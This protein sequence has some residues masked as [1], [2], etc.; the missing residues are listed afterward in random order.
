MGVLKVNVDG[1]WTEV[2]VTGAT[3]PKGDKGDTGATGASS[4]VPGPTGPAGPT[5]SRWRSIY[6]A[7]ANRA[8]LAAPSTVP[9]P[10]GP[11]GA[12]GATGP[13][14]PGVVPGGT[15]NQVL[16]KI[17]A[18]DYNTQWTT[19]ATGGVSTARVLTAG[20]GLTGGGDLSA[21]RTF[22]VGAGPGI[23]GAADTVS[24]ATTSIYTQTFANSAASSAVST[25]R[26]GQPTHRL[27]AV[28]IEGCGQWL[29]RTRRQ[30]SGAHRP[31]ACG[32]GSGDCRYHGTGITGR[33][34]CVGGHHLMPWTAKPLKV[35]TGSAWVAKPV[36]LSGSACRAKSAGVKRGAPPLGR[37]TS[38]KRTCLVPTERMSSPVPTTAS[39]AS[40]LVVPVDRTS[41]TPPCGTVAPTTP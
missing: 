2:P 9:G 1:T 13:A 26:C 24:V 30:R 3:G 4:T 27:P 40:S 34:R 14:G 23:T 5:G 17:N 21:N 31:V 35:W 7:W 18:T 25:R 37:A 39:T 12:A 6:G 19:P 20:N 32:G 29:R 33:R 36:G 22:D 16:T 38:S 8:S 28:C 11:A 15:A 10:T 41:T